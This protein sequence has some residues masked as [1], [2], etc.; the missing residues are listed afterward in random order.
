MTA[1]IGSIFGAGGGA[2]AA[3]A[4]LLAT[5]QQGLGPT[6]G[7]GVGRRHA[8]RRS[9][10]PT[11]IRRR[12]NYG[13]MTGGRVTGSVVVDPGSIQSLDPRSRPGRGGPAGGGDDG[14]GAGAEGDAAR[15]RGGS[16]PPG[17]E[18]PAGR[19][20]IATGN[21]LAVMGPQLGYFYPEIVQQVHLSGPGIEAQGAAV[22]GAA[23]YIL[24]GR[25]Q[26]Y[27]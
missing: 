19:P 6:G 20:A 7:A 5:L 8:R 21:T 11:T 18:L 23:M 13:P 24:I 1:F 25:T 9:R 17:V 3:N 2:E 4:E 26:D 14:D 15:P 16:R 12:F 10:G 22:P 27:A